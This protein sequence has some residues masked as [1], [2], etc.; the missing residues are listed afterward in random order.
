MSLTTK[1]ERKK[2]R[3]KVV[4]VAA[5]DM[6]VVVF[7]FPHSL[8]FTWLFICSIPFILYFALLFGF[9][10]FLLLLVFKK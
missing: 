4:V 7:F 6:V 10:P 8:I 5:A 9:V 2:E 1:Q 3:K